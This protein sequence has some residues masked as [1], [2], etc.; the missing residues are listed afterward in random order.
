MPQD[1]TS[2]GFSHNKTQDKRTGDLVV[3]K[4][5]KTLE[6]SWLGHSPLPPEKQ[7][8]GIWAKRTRRKTYSDKVN[9]QVSY[10]ELVR[11][12]RVL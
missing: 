3:S 12:E 7:L 6:Y 9:Y 1:S 10:Q 5:C 4:D 2:Q 11:Y 8:T